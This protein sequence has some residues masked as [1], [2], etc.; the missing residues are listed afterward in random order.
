MRWTDVFS[1]ETSAIWQCGFRSHA[2]QLAPA[3]HGDLI[4]GRVAPM[5]LLRGDVA[6]P[7]Q[8]PEPSGVHQFGGRAKPAC[9]APELLGKE[10]LLRRRQALERPFEKQ[11]IDPGDRDCIGLRVIAGVGTAKPRKGES[12]D[13]CEPQRQ[14]KP[15]G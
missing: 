9:P 11:R 6:R 15:E 1:S 8:L 7:R 13:E 4:A 14:Q 5:T 12:S 3:W 2:L 10:K